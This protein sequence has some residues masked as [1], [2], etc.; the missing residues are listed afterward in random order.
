MATPSW[1]VHFILQSYNHGSLREPK[2]IRG[3]YAVSGEKLVNFDNL[4]DDQFRQN[5]FFSPVKRAGQRW[6]NLLSFAVQVSRVLR[7]LGVA[8]PRLLSH[9]LTGRYEPYKG[10]PGGGIGIL[11]SS[12]ILFPLS[13]LPLQLVAI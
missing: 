7:V 4:V 10:Y 3:C 13:K 2:V 11:N 6:Y 5:Q 9:V 12:E 1:K 8:P